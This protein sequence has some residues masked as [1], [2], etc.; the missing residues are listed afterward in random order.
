[1]KHST[2]HMKQ[3]WHCAAGHLWAQVSGAVP[4]ALP[5]SLS[6]PDLQGQYRCERLRLA[7]SVHQLALEVHL[8]LH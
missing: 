8:L 3:D 4:D 1:M 2:A 5:L 7:G 6:Q